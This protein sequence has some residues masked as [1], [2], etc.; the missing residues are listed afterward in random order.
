MHLSE[1]SNKQLLVVYSE[2][3]E[4]IPNVSSKVL[5]SFLWQE[6]DKVKEEIKLREL[7]IIA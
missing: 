3:N 1:L 5:D 2:L 6:L 4:I 7:D